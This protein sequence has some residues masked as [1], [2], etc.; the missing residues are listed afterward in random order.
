[1]ST[2]NANF[3]PSTLY[4]ADNLDILRGM[5]S[6][7]V[8]LV[9]LD[10]PF[11]SKRMYQG[12][13]GTKAEGQSF[14]DT[15]SWNDAKEEWLDAIQD[16]WPTVYQAIMAAKDCNRPA[17]G[18]YIAFMAVRLAEIHRVL[19]PTGSMYLH[20]DTNAN[21]YLRAVC[22]AIFGQANFRNEIVWRRT[23][24]KNAVQSRFGS[25]HDSIFC[26]GKSPKKTI[27]NK[28]DA[29]RPYTD[30]DT[31]EGY[32]PDANG[33]LR[34]FSPVYAPGVRN[35]DSG[36]P[37]VFRGVVY[38]VPPGRHWRVPGGRSSG[39][40]TSEG[41]A[42]LD[43]QGRMYLADGGKLPMYIRYLDEMPGVA[44]DDVWA[45]IS[46]PGASESTGWATQK[47]V[48]LLERII[49]AG[50]NPGDII[51]DPFCGCATAMVAAQ[52]LDRQWVGIDQESYAIDQVRQRLGLECHFTSTPPI[53]TDATAPDM[54][55]VPQR[56]R[57]DPYGWEK[58]TNA[59]KRSLLA[60][61]QATDGGVQCPGCGIVLPERYFHL[62]H[63][64]PK[65]DPRSTNMIDNRILL[66]APCNQA[67]GNAMTMQGLISQNAAGGWFAPGIERPALER[68]LATVSV[69]IDNLKAA[70]P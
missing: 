55:A 6:E 3:A 60:E 14:K 17:M 45:D 33:R 57:R 67:K 69:A 64:R 21:S 46:I 10:P 28:A 50:S 54:R 41:W 39:E 43:R 61:I 48:A 34:A 52:N 37:V 22:D 15:W 70:Y 32:A 25:N 29:F 20:C 18:G 56:L 12:A 36:K 65:S 63:D 9:Y 5:N 27:F 49:K 66:C 16:D 68:L 24:S 30:K 23:H 35:G 47:P 8:D 7:S 13:P 44:L 19:K 40:T 58:F 38:E 53:R 59:E 31:P 1:M 26:Y 11:N 42:R 2:P 4:N 62:D 51:L